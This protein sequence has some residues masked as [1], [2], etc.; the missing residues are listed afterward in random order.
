VPKTRMN[1]HRIRFRLSISSEQFL[2]VYQGRTHFISVLAEDQRRIQFNAKHAKPFLT[3]DGIYGY[4]E[5]TLDDANRF[6]DLQR[7]SD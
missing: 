2:A 7:L 5:L 3:R 4:F 1:R 6:I